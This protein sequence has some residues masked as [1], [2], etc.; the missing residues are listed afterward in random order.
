MKYLDEIEAG[1]K[2]LTRRELRTLLLRHA[3]KQVPPDAN[4]RAYVPLYW[5]HQQAINGGHAPSSFW[6]RVVGC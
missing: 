6:R 5:K 4:I 2:R 3:G 1:A